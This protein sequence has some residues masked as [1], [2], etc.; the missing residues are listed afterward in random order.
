MAYARSL[1]EATG[2]YEMLDANGKVLYVGKARNLRRR[3]ESYF[4]RP[5][6]DPRIRAMV[7]RVAG[8]RV[9]LTANEGEALLLESRLIKANRPRYNVLLRDDKSYPYILFDQ[10]ERFPR[11]AFHR[12]AFRGRGWLYGPYPSAAA[13]RETIGLLQRLFRLRTCEDSVFR[14]R[15][16][17]CLE[18]QIGRCSAPC[19]GLIGEE[20]YLRDAKHARAFLEGRGA[21]VMDEL[22]R[23]MEAASA[24]LDFERAA[25]LRDAIARLREVQ[26]QSRRSG[27]GGDFDLAVCRRSGALYCIQLLFFRNGVNLGGRS[28]F[29]RVPPGIG[30]REALEAFLGQYYLDRMPPPEILLEAPLDSDWL[31]CGLSARA[32][33]TV[34][35]GPARGARAGW[36]ELAIRNAEAAL[37]TARAARGQRS[38]RLRALAALLGLSAP[39][40]RIECFDVSHTA[41]EATFASCVVFID[42]APARREYRRFRISGERPGD[43]LAAL[44]QALMRRY[45]RILAG[46]YQAPDLL[47]IDGGAAQ[48][49]QAE[50]ALERAGVAGESR[51]S[52]VAIA[53]GED[54]RPG[55][56]TLHL[57]AGR[58]LT[59]E[60]H[61][62]GFVLLRTIRDEAHRFALEGHRRARDRAR[63]VSLLDEI[64][65][66]G[67]HRRRLLLHHFGGV[68][69]VRA[70]G[71]SELMRVPGINRVLA[72]RIHHAVH[73][74]QP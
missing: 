22:V 18:Y 34:R 74:A 19:V 16:R 69:G 30:E 5:S 68:E 24:A 39:P 14:H 47:V 28:Y 62:E 50:S 38:E 70:A 72:E 41:G 54:R 56:E 60:V 61:D 63:S 35:I 33:G 71:V 44:D 66:I 25:A 1:S 11:I 27:G 32:G 40:R 52:L 49:A 58:T 57:S 4:T 13:V 45:R 29:P 48:L 7:A 73:R 17:P 31:A 67:P 9:T 12:G 20:Q 53:K 2:V 55:R 3:V 37:A 51:P 65:G 59:P 26:T 23:E 15:S 8:I 46:E 21:L 36:L 6:S 42:G 10:R 64:P 43:D